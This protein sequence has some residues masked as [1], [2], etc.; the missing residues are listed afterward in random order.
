MRGTRTGTLK[1]TKPT[2]YYHLSLVEK[3]QEGWVVKKHDS[4]QGE[5]GT[6]LAKGEQILFVG[7]SGKLIWVHA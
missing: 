5:K 3:I 1:Q 4:F 7:W 6:F 2:P